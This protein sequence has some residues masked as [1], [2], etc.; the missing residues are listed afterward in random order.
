MAVN[1]ADQL[2]IARQAIEERRRQREEEDKKDL[3]ALERVARLL[4]DGSAPSLVKGAQV[5]IKA[6][7]ASKNQSAGEEER[8]SDSDAPSLIS[9]VLETVLSRPNASLSPRLVLEILESQNFPFTRDDGKRILSVAQ[10]LRK[11]TERDQPKVRLLRRGSGRR[12]N[13]YRAQVQEINP[14]HV[15]DAARSSERTK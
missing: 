12:P 11:L 10:A 3:E 8:S 15:T 13:L 1:L 9:A 5:A 14:A 7:S 2:V 6:Q 4:P